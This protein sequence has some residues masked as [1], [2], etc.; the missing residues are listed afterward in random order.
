MFHDAALPGAERAV[1]EDG[2]GRR[3]R[4]TPALPL[5]RG[6]SWARS[7]PWLQ[8]CAVIVRASCGMARR[9]AKRAF[10]KRF[11]ASGWTAGSGAAKSRSALSSSTFSASRPLSR[12]SSMAASTRNRRIAMRAG[13]PISGPGAFRCC[14]SGTAKCR[15]T[16][17]ACAG[18]SS[19]PVGRPIR[20]SADGG[21]SDG[22]EARVSGPWANDGDVP[23]PAPPSPNLSHGALAPGRGAGHFWAPDCWAKPSNGGNVP[24][25][26]RSET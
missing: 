22:C 12:S 17:M 2:R 14:G 7:S 19:A 11:G 10:G 16:S 18:P 21:L 8:T 3:R 15:R 6:S 1:G 5:D 25:R 20:D 13:T 4:K 9:P 23:A 26:L 24:F